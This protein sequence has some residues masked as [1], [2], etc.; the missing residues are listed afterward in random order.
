MI[1][2]S[3]PASLISDSEV[4]DFIKEVMDH[5]WQYFEKDG[6]YDSFVP[7]LDLLAISN[8]DPDGERKHILTVLAGL[9]DKVKREQLEKA[10]ELAAE[11]FTDLTVIAVCFITEA[12]IKKLD[13]DKEKE[14]HDSGKRVSESDDK[15][16]ALI[17]AC[18][19]MNNLSGVGMQS[20][21][22]DKDNNI[23]LD[24][25]SFIKAKPYGEKS[26]VEPNLL[27]NFYI[28]YATGYG[29][30]MEKK[31]GLKADAKPR[32]S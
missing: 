14:W 3:D 24:E 7:I 2:L 23:V 32:E 17:T 22:R 11:K 10:G 9:D 5:N 26:D 25:E 1:N 12:W 31:Y 4:N 20:I 27:K 19:S 18:L 13:K 30:R 6:Q 15:T 21:K 16:E 8:T 29:R 28:G